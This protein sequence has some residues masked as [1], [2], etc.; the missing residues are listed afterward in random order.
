MADNVTLLS[1]RTEIRNRGEIRSAY[2]P[3]AELNAYINDSLAALYDLIITHDPTYFLKYSDISVVSGTKSYDLPSDYYKIIGAA[4]RDTSKADGYTVLE[5][6]N[7][8]ER[9]DYVHITYKYQTRYEVRA[10][11][12]YFHPL[13]GWTDTVRL[14]YI[15]T[16]TLLSSDS[17][18]WD[19]INRWTE[20][21]VCDC[22]IK[23]AS[24]EE[25][26]PSVWISQR[27]RTEARI[28]NNVQ[29]D[30][31]KPRTVTD[32]YRRYK[33]GWPWFKGGE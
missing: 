3:D 6:Y 8:D 19:A 5:R 33:W 10:D 15:P 30:R 18:S 12:I 26:D 16:P 13:P 1:L 24:K 20:W 31:S 4:V 11:K 28:T 32:V 29:Q 27:D 2:I 17:D 14:E 9:Y 21:V 23:A 7:F 25:T 22:L